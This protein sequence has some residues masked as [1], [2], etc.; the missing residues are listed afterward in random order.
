L[1][2]EKSNIYQFG[3]G[4]WFLAQQLPWLVKA[5]AVCRKAS[6]KYDQTALL[7]VSD[8]PIIMI[9]PA[10][11]LLVVPAPIC[12]LSLSFMGGVAKEYGTKLGCAKYLRR[13]TY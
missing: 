13:V 6:N 7:R 11:F 2:E 12:C 3:S 9:R 5:T 1:D 8:W 10:G 4:K